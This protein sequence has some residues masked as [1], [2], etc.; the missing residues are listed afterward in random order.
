MAVI[1]PDFIQ[2]VMFSRHTQHLLGV[3]RAG[4]GTLVG[5]QENILELDHTGVGKK[6][7][8][9]PARNE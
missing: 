9:I 1:P 6:Q 7:G 8:G 4:I 5:A 3:D 2:V